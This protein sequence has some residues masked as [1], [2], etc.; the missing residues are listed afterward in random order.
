MKFRSWKIEIEPKKF[1]FNGRKWN[2][3]VTFTF[4]EVATIEFAY[5]QA[6]VEEMV[7]YG[8]VPKRKLPSLLTF[9]Q[10]KLSKD[11]V[12]PVE[13]NMTIKGRD[14]FIFG[15]ARVS[16]ADQRLDIQ[17]EALEKYGCDRI[18]T[19]KISGVIEEKE[20]L[21][22][23]DELQAGD[24]LV[25]TRIDR[26]GRDAKQLI[27]FIYSLDQRGVNLIIL[28]MNIDTK[29]PM[30]KFFIQIMASISELERSNL[31]E[32]QRK[33]IENRR[34]QGLHM[35]R[36]PQYKKPQ[37]EEAVRQVQETNKV[38]KEIC[39]ATGVPRASLY[40]ELKNRGITR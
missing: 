35:G 17:I 15:Y 18:L 1:S 26:L 19:E 3:R 36:K 40:R 2:Y 29:T 16:A 27:E 32:K 34:K 25:V 21:K 23:R 6:K 14:N 24:T 11:V 7:Q 28:D 37:M 20:L 38:M 9:V 5:D 22:L 31:K 10:E 39:E 8:N 4:D 12:W 30:G 33:G 13:E